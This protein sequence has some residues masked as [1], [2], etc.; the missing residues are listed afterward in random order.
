MSDNER[1]KLL[2]RRGG[3]GGR[4][5]LPQFMM[6]RGVGGREGGREVG[7]SYQSKIPGQY[8]SMSVW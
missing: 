5:D 1:V 3:E 7:A 4:G 2:E 8:L 6:R